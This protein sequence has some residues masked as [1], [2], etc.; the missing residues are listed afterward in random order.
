MV[1][2][3]CSGKKKEKTGKAKT[4]TKT[5]FIRGFV[6]LNRKGRLLQ[7][8][9]TEIF[10]QNSVTPTPTPIDTGELKFYPPKQTGALLVK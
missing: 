1:I 6:I 5:F 7:S 4:E 2:A 8:V 9:L 3:L 10:P